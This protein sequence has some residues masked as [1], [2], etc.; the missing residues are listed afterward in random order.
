MKKFAAV[1]LGA[2]TGRVIVGDLSSLDII[3]RFP[4]KAVRVKDSLHWDILGIYAEIKSGL[5]EA[6]RKYG[7]EIVSIGIDTWGVDYALLDKNGDLLGNP[8]HY[9]DD[10]TNGVMEEVFRLIPREDIYEETGIQF[11]PFNTI[12]QLYAAIKQAPEVLG[13]AFHYLSIPDLLNYWLTGEMRNEF[14]HFT[15]TQLYNPRKKEWSPR[16]MEALGVDPK[17]FCQIVPSGTILGLLLPSVAEELGAGPEVKVIVPGCHDTA[18]A[19]AAVPTRGENTYAYLSSGTWSLLGI[20][21]DQPII[22]SQS[23]E[24]NFTNEGSVSGGFRFL[25]NIMGLWILQEC[26]AAWDQTEEMRDW[27]DIVQAA[28]KAEDRGFR[29]DVDD[30]LFLGSSLTSGPMPGR[31]RTYLGDRNQ[32][33]P[34]TV[35]EVALCVFKSLAETYARVFNQLETMAGRRLEE[36][37]IIGGGCQ[38]DYL[39]RLTAEAVNRPVFAGPAEATALGNIL[40]QAVALGEVKDLREGRGLIAENFEIVTYERGENNE[41]SGY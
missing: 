26:K 35:G 17:I 27:P 28:E 40:V 11:L 33:V 32:P 24:G 1:D 13:A 12:F 41:S 6:F 29:I 39:C 18:S 34:E 14:S 2:S 7:D 37:Y 4:S 19:V 8:Y 38:N 3:S 36:L 23:Y 15:T 31:I 20:E 25:K 9:R 30:L 22:S 10:R 21:S 5:K 16:I